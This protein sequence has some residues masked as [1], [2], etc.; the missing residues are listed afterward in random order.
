MDEHT[1]P[2]PSDWLAALEE[3]EAD[4]VAGRI[5]SGESVIRDL[6]ASLARLEAKAEAKPG[7]PAPR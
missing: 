6:R 5:V 3:S 1:K 2:A 7:A 4:V